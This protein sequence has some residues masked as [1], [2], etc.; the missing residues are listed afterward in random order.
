MTTT[1]LRTSA[2]IAFTTLT[3]NVLAHAAAPIITTDM[4]NTDVT[5]YTNYTL[6]AS[7][8]ETY[9]AL[10]GFANGV[11]GQ[12][13]SVYCIGYVVIR[14]DSISGYEKILC[15]GGADKSI[16]ATTWAIVNFVYNEDTGYWHEVNL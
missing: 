10:C 15:S 7:G 13:I 16:L 8:A 9:Y 12:E 2:D 1:D 4:I 6:D 14:H 5:H 11:H 3:A